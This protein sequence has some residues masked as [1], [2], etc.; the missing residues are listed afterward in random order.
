MVLI[1][2]VNKMKYFLTLII[3]TVLWHNGELV[4]KVDA[5]NNSVVSRGTLEGQHLKIVCTHVS[6]T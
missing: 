4:K 5:S 3:A 6:N 1:G 2:K